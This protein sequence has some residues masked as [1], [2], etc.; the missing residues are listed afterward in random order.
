MP[1]GI[2]TAMKLSS[3]PVFLGSF[4]KPGEVLLAG[5]FGQVIAKTTDSTFELSA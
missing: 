1:I 5:F 2:D 3:T 4:V